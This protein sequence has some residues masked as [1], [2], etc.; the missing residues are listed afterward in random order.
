[1]SFKSLS[2]CIITLLIIGLVGTYFWQQSKVTSV[3]SQLNS[4]SSKLQTT[5]ANL[6]KENSNLTNEL[7]AARKSAQSQSLS[8]SYTAGSQCQE[9]QIELTDETTLSGGFAGSGEIFSFE[10]ISNTS[11]NL[12]GYPGFLALDSTG[13]VKPDGP[14]VDTEITIAGTKV[15]PHNITLDPQAKA[16]FLAS[17]W[18][19][20]MAEGPAFNTSIIE[21]TPPG[22]S[23]PLEILD[24]ISMFEVKNINV[25]PLLNQQ[26]L[27]KLVSE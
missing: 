15:G 8:N 6:D 13:N 5:Q 4:T 21:S 7:N 10:N 17:G 27:N 3:Q 11:C 9:S 23:L 19:N 20:M 12:S 1:M 2:Y 26:E 25:S 14:V 22:G 16:Y 18:V 24:N